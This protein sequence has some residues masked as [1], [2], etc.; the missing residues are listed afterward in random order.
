MNR[1]MPS[2]CEP[3][4]KRWR[5]RHV[6]EEFHVSAR[7]CKLDCLI[8]SQKSCVPQHLVDVAGFKVGVRP[9]ESVREFPRQREGQAIAPPGGGARECRVF[10]CTLQ[11]QL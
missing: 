10:R 8:L 1:I 4:R 7:C 11:G 3:F 2:S 5:Q 9:L 6:D